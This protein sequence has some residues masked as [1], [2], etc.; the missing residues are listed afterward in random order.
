MAEKTFA[1]KVGLQQRVFP[2]YRA[3]FIDS[4]AERCL[5]GLGF[6]A[7]SPRPSESIESGKQL[8]KANYTRA[9]NQHLFSGPF[10]LC[11]QTN[12]LDWLQS[13]RP[14]VLI[15]EANPRYLNTPAAVRWM[16]QNTKPVIAWGLGAPPVNGWLAPIRQSQR[17]RF[18]NQ[19][20]GVIA[21]SQ[22]GA[23]EYIQMGIPADRVF[24]APNAATLAPTV[25]PP[26]REVGKRLSIVFVGRLQARKRLD[27]LL[28]VC[29][30][31]P[32]NIQP[33]LTIIGDGPEKEGLSALAGQIYPQAVFTGTKISAELDPYF[34]QANLFVLPGTGGLAVQ[35]AM[36]SGLAVVVAEGDGTQSNLVTARNGWQVVPGSEADL[37]RVL[38]EAGKDFSRLSAMG[39]ESFRIVKEEINIEKMVDAFITAIERVT[40]K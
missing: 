12:I 22:T 8:Q 14:D 33:A 28:Q 34:R 26:V 38:L 24:I 1:G 15:V 3:P 25:P 19:F 29:A 4:L 16:H 27:L 13:C 23:N 35:Q 30:E 36:A 6:F 7:G 17:K 9:N 11:R 31:L 5:G 10:Y 37:H 18:L 32:E 39:M 20:D 2:F 21:Y 40:E